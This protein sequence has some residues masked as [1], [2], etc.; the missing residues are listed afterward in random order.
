MVARY[1][2]VPVGVR[3]LGTPW[4]HVVEPR[5]KRQGS[6]WWLEKTRAELL[7]KPS[8][9]KCVWCE[10]SHD[11]QDLCI[12]EARCYCRS[13]NTTHAVAQKNK[14]N[15]F[16]IVPAHNCVGKRSYLFYL[17]WGVE[18]LFD[19]KRALR[20]LSTESFFEIAP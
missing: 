5:L 20:K 18:D 9:Q 10:H 7:R 14:L 19:G 4:H 15:A 17:P 16:F 11:S 8:P 13:D 2:D 1:S 3:V 6:R 12:F